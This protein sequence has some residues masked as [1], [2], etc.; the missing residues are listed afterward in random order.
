MLLLK[1]TVTAWISQLISLGCRLDKIRVWFPAQ[2]TDLC[3]LHGIH[4]DSGACTVFCLVGT[5]GPFPR[6]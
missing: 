2:T 5:W 4:A 1:V 6:G 3:L